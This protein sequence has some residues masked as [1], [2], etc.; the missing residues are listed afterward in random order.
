MGEPAAE[1]ESAGDL[2]AARELVR[3]AARWFIAGLGAIGVVLV[4][5]SQLSSVG[6]LPAGSA[7]L[8][9]A[10]GGVVIGLLAILWAMW[11]VVDVL[12]GWRWTFE[13]VVAEWT[14]TERRPRG[15]WRQRRSRAQH[16]VGWFLREAPTALGGF[17]SPIEI[18][19]LY[20]ESQPGRAGLDDLVELMDE[21]LD[22]AATVHLESRFRALRRQIAGGVLVGAA[23]IILFAWAANPAIPEQPAPS[24][25]NADL[26]GADLRGASLRNADLTGADLT[27]A[28]LLDAD[29]RGARIDDVI[30]ANTTC[31]DG[32]D[33]DATARPDAQGRLVGGTC[34]GHLSPAG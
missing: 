1:R 18:K 32:S 30:W 12:A 13:A 28:N 4:A 27:G 31:P 20:D 3:S 11:R 14:A 25:R 23:G 19:K 26:R 2:T 29:L 24:L 8:Y 34:E 17:A 33:S 22:K 5:G 9:L 21:L 6:A 10:I 15:R 7:R 16:P